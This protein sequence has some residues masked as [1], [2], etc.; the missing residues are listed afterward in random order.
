MTGQG[1][2]VDLSPADACN[3][4]KAKGANSVFIILV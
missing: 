2:I 1:S 4:D 3:P